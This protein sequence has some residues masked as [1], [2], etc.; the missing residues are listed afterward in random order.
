MP[1]EAA[2]ALLSKGRCLAALGR[3]PEAAAPLVA[4]RKIFARLGARPA[5][6]ET[7]VALAAAG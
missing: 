3:G 1:Y 2:Q 5:L 7:Q 4:A 6:E